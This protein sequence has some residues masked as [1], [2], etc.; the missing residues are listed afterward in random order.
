TPSVK[1]SITSGE[2]ITHGMARPSRSSSCASRMVSIYPTCRVPTRWAK[3]SGSSAF[4]R[5]S[6]GTLTSQ[7]STARGGDRGGPEDR[8]G[9]VGAALGR[10]A[11]GSW[12][13][14]AYAAV[15]GTRTGAGI[16]GDARRWQQRLGPLQSRRGHGQ[17][18]G[19]RDAGRGI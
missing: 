3:L 5:S 11:T 10:A 1:I 17:G 8:S 4:L 19:R 2:S 13:Q 6:E 18:A 14:L 12:Q 7:N 15:G 16:P 9:G